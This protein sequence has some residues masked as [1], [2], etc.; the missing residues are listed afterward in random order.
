MKD[1]TTIVILQVWS[2]SINATDSSVQ[3]LA[4]AWLKKSRSEAIK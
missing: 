4:L 1:E 2:K 3:A